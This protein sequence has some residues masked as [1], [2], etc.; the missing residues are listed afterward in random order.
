MVSPIGE[1]A[2]VFLRCDSGDAAQTAGHEFTNDE[3]AIILDASK[4]TVEGV[5]L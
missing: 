3:G 1:K 5:E 4:S 2:E